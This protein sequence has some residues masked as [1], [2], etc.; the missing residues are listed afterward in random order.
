MRIDYTKTSFK[1]FAGD[2]FEITD[3]ADSIKIGA[4]DPDPGQIL[5]WQGQI[6]ISYNLKAVR[7]GLAEAEFSEYQRPLRWRPDRPMRLELIAEDGTIATIPLRIQRYAYSAQKRKGIANVH[8]ILDAIAID[9]PAEQAEFTIDRTAGG[10]ELTTVIRALVDLAYKSISLPT[11]AIDLTGIFGRFDDVIS[12]RNPLNDAGDLGAGCWRFMRVRSDE[13]IQFMSLDTL[14]QSVLFRRHEGQMELDPEM[15]GFADWRSRAI[16]TGHFQRATIPDCDSLDKEQKNGLDAQQRPMIMETTSEAAYATVYPGT[17]SKSTTLTA[18]EKKTIIT[19]YGDSDFTGTLAA[20]WNR[21][22]DG[23]STSLNGDPLNTPNPQ[24]VIDEIPVL[25]RTKE[26]GAI[27]TITVSS[28]PFGSIFPDRPPGRD[29]MNFYVASVELQTERKKCTFRPRGVA[30]PATE[31]LILDLVVENR[32]L[33]APNSSNKATFT[34]YGP[35]DPNDPNKGLRCLEPRPQLEPRVTQPDFKMETVPVR[36]ECAIA[37][38]GWDPLVR[39]PLI[40]DFGFIPSQVHANELA[41]YVAAQHV[42]KGSPH[43]CTMPIPEEW[44]A[45]DCPPI[46]RFHHGAAEYEAIGLALEISDKGRSL[47]FDALR[48]G[49]APAVPVPANPLPYIPGGF[50][51]VGGRPIVGFGGQAGIAVQLTIGR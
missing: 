9:R 28:R 41:C 7:S 2:G 27:G 30:A 5:T 15:R 26:T 38:N 22:T 11:P 50:Q 3:Y 39:L 43:T 34:E 18:S 48:L 49:A 44:I 4:A 51:I 47:S 1:L 20:I 46:F 36:G 37:P 23:F 21:V 31:G 14:N 35:V 8:Q 33:V 45:G 25:K 17:G 16:V 32:E 42:R 24:V 29:L 10:A 13:S 6:E 19:Q 40:K 12:T